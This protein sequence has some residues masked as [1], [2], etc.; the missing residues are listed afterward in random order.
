MKNPKPHGVVIAGTGYAG[1]HFLQA[2]MANPRVKLLGVTS[3]RF[4]RAL[5]VAN[6]HDAV[7]TRTFQ[8]L[9]EL[10]GAEIAI[11]ATPN[12]LHADQT[13][14]ALEAGKH[15]LCEKPMVTSKEACRR[16]VSA[17]R[18]TDRKIGIGQ[19]CRFSPYFRIA[20]DMYATGKLGQALLV[21]G[22]YIHRV[23][24]PLKSW[25]EDTF[26]G[27]LAVLGGGVHPIDLMRWVAGEIVEVRSASSSALTLGEVGLHDNVVADLQFENGCPGRVFISLSAVRPYSIDISVS[28]TKGTVVNDG[29]FL[30][31]FPEDEGFATI[32]VELKREHPYFAEE[33][34]DLIESIE[35]DRPPL[36]TAEDGA[37]TVMVCLA[38]IEAIASGNRV[39]VERI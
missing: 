25:W 6:K 3:G 33:L 26:P 1:S 23:S 21:E 28:G 32:P 4:D 5:E 10:P 14:T 15:V 24:P 38:I 11:I 12:D 35:Y 30:D 18:K 39:Q 36:V 22:T 20:K 34:A 16:V 17:A 13:I 31:S 19:I 29:V 27:S 8:E 7:A 2:A 37:R 9:V